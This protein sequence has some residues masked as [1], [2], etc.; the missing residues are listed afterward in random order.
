MKEC[1]IK[2]FFKLRLV[3]RDSEA[4]RTPATAYAQ[5]LQAIRLARGQRRVNLKR[6]VVSG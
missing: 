6:K 3:S 5:T 4:L 1:V 2:E